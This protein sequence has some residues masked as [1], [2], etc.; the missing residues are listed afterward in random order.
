M[1][2]FARVLLAGSIVALGFT[3]PVW[4]TPA[5][6]ARAGYE[7]D[8][9]GDYA[10]AMKLYQTAAAGGD[11]YAMFNIGAIYF[12]GKGVERSYILAMKW[13]KQ[14]A[15]K[16]YAAAQA[17]MGSMYEQG[18]G[19]KR[20]MAEASKWYTMAAN[21]GVLQSQNALGVIYMTGDGA[22][23]QPNLEQ[24]YYWFSIAAKQDAS[25]TARAGRVKG[26]LQPAQLADLDKKVAAFK[27]KT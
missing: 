22:K 19:V 6:D 13:Y 24:A 12:D 15:E 2:S 23:M 14:A 7:A 27:P 17:V 25:A 21:Q 3:A 1:K 10:T 16:G 8:Q 5:D 20:D 9:K 11:A 4:A 18:Q 26:K